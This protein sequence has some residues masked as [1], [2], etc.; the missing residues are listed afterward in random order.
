MKIRILSIVALGTFLLAAEPVTVPPLPSGAYPEWDSAK[1]WHADSGFR[2]E[3]CLN[4]LWRFRSAAVAP[5]APVFIDGF[6]GETPA[7][8]SIGIASAY[9]ATL[10]TVIKKSGRGAMKAVFDIPQRQN[11]YHIT[12]DNVA[13]KP[14]TAY[15]LSAWLKT[16]L[17]SGD[18]SLEMQDMRNNFGK[19]TKIYL[20]QRG[21]KYKGTADWKKIRL[22]FRTPE[23]CTAV[24]IMLRNYGDGEALKG[25]VWFDDIT[26]DTAARPLTDAVLPADG[27]WGFAKV[28]GSPKDSAFATY[29]HE[30]DTLRNNQGALEYAWYQRTFIVPS[31]WNG[32]RICV[33][34]ERAANS[35]GVFIDG[36][37]AGD[38]GYFGGRIDVTR[39]VTPGK[40]HT[41]SILTRARD[42]GDLSEQLSKV[43]PGNNGIP[44]NVYLVSAP[45]GHTLAPFRI[46][47]SVKKMSVSV[48]AAL[49]SNET[50]LPSGH[51]ITCEI[52]REGKTVKTFSSPIDAGKAVA[53]ALF[54]EAVLWD[55]GRPSLYAMTVT[56]RNDRGDVIDR[57]PP[58]R[59]GFREFE[60]RG[61]YCYLNGIKINIHPCAFSVRYS[62]L[63][64][65]CIAR[66]CSN[67][68]AEGRNYIYLE[69]VDRPGNTEGLQE[70]LN[71]ADEMGILMAI[72]P[73]Q[74]NT[75]WQRLEEP[76]VTSWFRS[77]L[78]ERAERVWNHPSLVLYR[79]NMNFDCYAQDQNPLC[80]DG[81]QKPDTN[82]QLEKK[83]AA[84][85]ISAAIMKS[86]D[87][88][89]GAYHHAS[90]NMGD[91]YTLNNYLCWPEEQDLREWLSIW[92]ARG[93]KP[94]MMAEFDLPYPG[95]FSMNDP[96]SWWM[97]E[98]LMTE[99]GAML[100][101]E[102]SYALEEDDFRIFS[103]LAWN[104]QKNKWESAYGYYCRA[105][106]DIADECSSRYYK[107]TFQAWRTWGISGGMNG[108][109]YA[110]QRLKKRKTSPHF[111]S[112]REG[113]P[114]VTLP[115]DWSKLQT[116]GYSPDI[117]TYDCRGTG[118][119]LTYT[120][121]GLPSEAEYLEPTK[122]GKTVSNVLAPLYAYIAGSGKDWPSQDHAFYTGESVKKSV[123]LINDQRTPAVFRVQWK[124][125]LGNKEIGS[126]KGTATVP[127]AETA[128]VPISFI[129]PAVIGRTEGTVTAE[130]IC[131][132]KDIPVDAFAFQ[133]YA[134]HA[135]PSVDFS[136]WALYDPK[137]KTAAAFK[138]NGI[139]LRS[140]KDIPDGLDVLV[141]GCEALET[142][143]PPAFLKTLTARAAGGMQ[144]L[145]LEQTADALNV[146]FRLRTIPRGMREVCVRDS[147]HPV[148]SGLSSTDMANWRGNTTLSPL[149]G[150]PPSLTTS[151]RWERVWRCSQRGVVA[152]IIVEKPHVGSFRPIVDCGFDLRYTALWESFEG[153][154]RMVFCQMDITD[155]IGID[156][157]ADIL[158]ANVIRNCAAWKPAPAAK[159]ALITSGN[160]LA[161][162]APY[163]IIGEQNPVSAAGMQSLV[164]GPGCG[165]WITQ[166]ADDVKKVLADGGTVIAA[167]LFENDASALAAAGSP[168]LKFVK[169]T[170]FTTLLSGSMPPS[171]RGVGPGDVHW[172]E[173]KE[174]M[175][176]A[177]S[178]KGSWV[179]DSGAYAEIRTGSGRIVWIPVLPNVFDEKRRPDLIFTKVNASRV[180]ALALVNAGI[181]CATGLA[182][183]ISNAQYLAAAE[184]PLSGV[185]RMRKD[186]DKKAS[187]A[188]MKDDTDEKS[189][190]W[191]DMKVP[192]MWGEMYPDWNGYLGD[193]WHRFR[194]TAPAAAENLPL[195]FYA[196]TIDDTDEVW[197]NGVK[198]GATTTNTAKW[199]ETER[200]Y[201]IPAGLL[202]IGSENILTV[203]I[204]NNYQDAGFVGPVRLQFSEPTASIAHYI[205]VRKPRDDPYAYMRW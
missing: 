96:T 98:P 182:E 123:V 56:L 31:E 23:G 110:T 112:M 144:V 158:T 61:R 5:T 9:S 166:H 159:T 93:T 195:E 18:I 32:R 49:A 105:V 191:V 67:A 36:V 176:V 147:A 78:A 164:L 185:W 156:P 153:R 202:R 24:K 161:D 60:I 111:S 12:R 50:A 17:S 141:I 142:N 171:L 54:P 137:G 193:V 43:Q 174:V 179:S 136:K 97:N 130:I 30:K 101:G 90:G 190:T 121:P 66:W 46:E 71:V 157:A 4:G 204:N 65:D 73:T 122:W 22:E 119:I 13:V 162:F 114:P 201:R 83:F 34:A 55:I 186:T 198:I 120:F 145:V 29:W 151:Q 95:S 155:R 6:E 165:V 87:P 108:W 140:V 143:T 152:S 139:T 7:G 57:T 135:A 132:K 41:L 127:P 200:H 42:G 138:R 109:E 94:L 100:L 177:A 64:R 81:V 25:T 85:D 1:A 150:P 75:F 84:A 169:K 72:T 178:P 146:L 89:R 113:P 194:F 44:G 167:G 192:G 68:V 129:V 11:F 172:R 125:M 19:E 26:L 47:T 133:A 8:W 58:E 168:E 38:A 21:E 76:A 20:V 10:D 203:R 124:V 117:F 106:P 88:A 103:D 170:V 39:L 2:G 131:E 116:P 99:Y 154:G 175:T 15:V 181:P 86:I 45:Y 107:T 183:M 115:T 27:N 126:G 77:K 53:T 148:V 205:D 128:Q 160:T 52:T 188:W 51:T 91:L 184:I 28:P 37:K 102:K 59:F 149:D 3:V 70:V 14:S 35:L 163:R 69:T 199:W 82:S 40:Q 187:E 79:M 197:L 180:I 134:K 63:T 196:K 104:R 173:K 118:E 62:Y 16:E 74:I 80:L 92:A 189:D 33:Y 48:F